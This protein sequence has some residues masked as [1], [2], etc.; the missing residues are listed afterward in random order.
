MTTKAKKMAIDEIAAAI[1]YKKLTQPFTQF[2]AYE[3][4]IIDNKGQ[5]IDQKNSD[6]ISPVEVLAIALKGV[7]PGPINFIRP[8]AVS[9]SSLRDSTLYDRLARV[10]KS[11]PAN[12][13]IALSKLKNFIS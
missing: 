2:D 6:N 7:A 5:I 9:L 13:K 12:V 11:T 4:G 8:Q 10:N 3:D 1:V